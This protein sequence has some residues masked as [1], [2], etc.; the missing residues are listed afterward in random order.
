MAYH[1]D[2][3]KDYKRVVKWVH[4]MQYDMAAKHIVKRR[5][6]E[7]LVL[8]M[9]TGTP[10]YAVNTHREYLIKAIIKRHKRLG[11]RVHFKTLPGGSQDVY[12]TKHL[13]DHIEKLEPRRYL[14]DGTVYHTRREAREAAMADYS[15]RGPKWQR[16][17]WAEWVTQR[18]FGEEA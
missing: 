2:N 1:R 15:Y 5:L 3:V 10:S 8:K 7:E 4:T 11:S 18:S 9:L 12:Y 14:Y 16:D 17:I 13:V 6:D